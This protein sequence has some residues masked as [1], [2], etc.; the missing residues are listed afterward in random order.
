MNI[1]AK[2][3]NA[4]LLVRL[5]Q[6]RA[7]KA[8]EHRVGQQRG[9]GLMQVAAL[10][11]VAFVHKHVDVAF[12]LKV[13]GQ[14][15]QRC[16]KGLGR[17]L[18]GG[19]AVF[20][21]TTTLTIFA[22]KFVH[23]RAQQRF[24][25]VV[26]LGNQVCTAG[27]A[28]D[29]FAH[30]REHLFNLF[31]QLCP[32]GNDHHPRA[33]AVGQNPLGQPHHGQAFATALG[34]PNDAALTPGNKALRRFHPKVLVL[35][36]QLFGARIKHHKVV[37]QLQQAGLA[38]HLQQLPVQCVG[39]SSKVAA[40]LYPFQV[41]LFRCLDA[42]VAQTLGIVARHHPLHGGE[43]RLNELFLL[44]IQVLADSFGHRHRGALELQHP[45]SHAI[46][47]EHDVG[48]LC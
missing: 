31:V 45:H 8:D 42:A 2:H 40:F 32:V 6:R 22:A 25:G 15:A 3:L 44:V 37:H 12:G 47:V 35:A 7:G 48:P 43:K 21:V 16:H 1:A 24:L 26:Q 13:F 14:V 34:V 5:E 41:V 17:L 11:A 23:Q 36:A 39:L 10:G 30:T 28:A 18:A 27:G 4:L 38:A 19:S 9:H 33:G 29:G 20:L 46:D